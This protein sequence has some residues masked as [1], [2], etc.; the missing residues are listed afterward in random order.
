MNTSEFINQ[1]DLA[2]QLEYQL[3]DRH[4]PMVSSLVLVRILGYASPEAFRQA[5]A[6]KTIPVPI[7]KIKN[8]RGYF[9]LTKDIANWMTV[10][11][12]RADDQSITSEDAMT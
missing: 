9:A 1:S 7:F 11:R 10:Q 4:G 3:T 5:V 2:A 8:R 12:S 6:R